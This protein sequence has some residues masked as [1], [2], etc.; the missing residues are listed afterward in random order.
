MKYT[1]LP[2]VD[3]NPT[4]SLARAY[5]D[6]H[7]LQYCREIYFNAVEAGATFVR[8]R[9]VNGIKMAWCDDGHGMN[10]QDLLR[11]INGRN[12]SSKSVEGRHG[13]FGVGLKDSTLT[14]NPYGVVIVSRTSEKP[15][16][17]MIWLHQ[18]EGVSGAQVL[19]SEEMRR[20]FCSTPDHADDF[21]A[22]Y[23]QDLH[24]VDFEWVKNEFG[25]E[26]FT[27]DGVD[28][29]HLF[30]KCS[31]NTI[32][33][34][35][36][37]Y[38]NSVTFDTDA[39]KFH[40]FFGMKLSY[41]PIRMLIPRVRSNRVE[42]IDWQKVTT[43]SELSCPSF[44]QEF[45]NFKITTYL[46]PMSPKGRKHG[47]ARWAGIMDAKRSFISGIKYKNEIFDYTDKDAAA[48][49][50]GLYYPEVYKRVI[51]MV[52]PAMY[53]E[54][55]GIGCYPDGERQVLKYSD[56]RFNIEGQDVKSVL[57]EV[58]E[59]YINNMPEELRQLI[60][61]EVQKTLESVERSKKISQFRKFFKAPKVE[62]ASQTSSDG[63][64]FVLNESGSDQAT[65]GSIIDDL[66]KRR[67]NSLNPP[68]PSA[69][70]TSSEAGNSKNKS[71]Q[72]G[73]DASAD[74]LDR[75]P[76]PKDAAVVFVNRESEAWPTY[77]ALAQSERGGL[78]PFVYTGIRR[79]D[80]VNVIYVN[81]DSSIIT[82]L[83]RS[84]LGWVNNRGAAKM[85]MSEQ[86]VLE[87]LVK[88]FIRDFMPVSL[89]HLNGDREKIKLGITVTD[90]VAI[91]AMF[92]GTWQIHMNLH[93]YYNHYRKRV[94]SLSAEEGSNV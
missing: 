56:P 14:P 33:V 91:Y 29:M 85:N 72:K 80:N 79:G 89:S 5:R 86:E 67:N 53:D 9:P 46:K 26:S 7:P 48:K 15:M 93:E 68:P 83:V 19:I 43:L 47:D 58:Q 18:R 10:P 61:E 54:D 45:K 42:H 64:L 57:G 8:V 3:N 88:P 94:L 87:A 49:Q 17:G 1:T 55:T 30:K 70:K 59:W 12:S 41:M 69:K 84:A 32:V 4:A 35:M 2:M 50:W 82:A 40:N 39:A 28:W 36:G 37:E 74:R 63:D 34:L 23:L 22:E 27:I 81:T 25:H 31:A 75:R 66:F 6:M 73:D 16:G 21:A 90:P 38:A 60:N 24:S 20:D 65:Q 13:N 52:E 11:L 77:E 51:I 78:F 92:H 71:G 62:R 76:S 44:N